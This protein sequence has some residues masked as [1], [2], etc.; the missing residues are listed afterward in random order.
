M[1]NWSIPIPIL[2]KRGGGGRNIMD[3]MTSWN[4]DIYIDIKIM[5]SSMILY[6][7]FRE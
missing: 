4:L 6:L 3:S 1:A 2:Q 7:T 5:F